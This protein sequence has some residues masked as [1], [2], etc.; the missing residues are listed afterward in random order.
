[1]YRGYFQGLFTREVA[2]STGL[3]LALMPFVLGHYFN[4]PEWH[5]LQIFY[6]LPLGFAF[7]VTDD[8]GVP[9]KFIGVGEKVEDLIPFEPQGFVEA[10][11]SQE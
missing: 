11:F 3:L 8:L 9:I 7:A 4:H 10:L 5:V 2:S 6:T 1:M